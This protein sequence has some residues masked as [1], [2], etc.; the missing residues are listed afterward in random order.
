[1]TFGG[2][3]DYLWSEGANYVRGTEINHMSDKSWSYDYHYYQYTRP[4]R[5]NL[6]HKAD[7]L[8]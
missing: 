4:K 6:F 2:H 5:T 1:M 7:C 3:I 8:T